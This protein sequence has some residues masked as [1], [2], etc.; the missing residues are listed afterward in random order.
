MP[1]LSIQTN[2]NNYNQTRNIV[3]NGALKLKFIL[4]GIVILLVGFLSG[5]LTK[6]LIQG[7][8]TETSK[9]PIDSKLLQNPLVYE[10]R[11][12]VKGK[13]VQKDENSFTLE[14]DSGNRITITNKMP[15]GEIFRTYFSELTIPGPTQVELK[16]ISLGT[17]L[18]GDFFIFKGGPD[19][20]VG[21]SFQIVK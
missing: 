2:P 1:D 20:P 19:I 17:S 10:W 15:T 18:R 12:S 7:R 16:D 11:G 6:N 5:F 21:S 8:S 14:N 9:L 3:N 13:L 4:V